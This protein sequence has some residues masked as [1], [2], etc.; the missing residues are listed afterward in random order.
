MISI[1]TSSALA[2]QSIRSVNIDLTATQNRISTGLK[3]ASAKDNAGIWATAQT[4]RSEISGAAA[5]DDGIA[6]LKGKADVA[7]NATSTVSDL[8]VKIRDKLSAAQASGSDLTSIGNEISAIQTQITAVIAGAKFQGQNWLDNT[9]TTAPAVVIGAASD[10]TTTSLSLALTTDMD[11]YDATTAA[12]GSLSKNGTASG[13]SILSF[14]VTSATT[15]TASTGSMSIANMISDV[16]TALT[17]VNKAAAA[18]GSFSNSLESTQGFLK[19]LNTIKQTAL[20]NLVDANMEEES[21]KLQAL[22]VKQQLAY[23]GLSIANQANQN[24]LRLFQ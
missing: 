23:Q 6:T 15:Q 10:G 4:I 11:L 20:G 5:I 24:V 1:N 13:A 22:Q 2:L 21:A 16:A 7:A 8:L 3:V 14:A 9:V 17:S 19:N 12:N 18:F